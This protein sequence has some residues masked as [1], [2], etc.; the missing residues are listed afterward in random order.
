MKRIEQ[1][2]L[3]DPEME[4]LQMVLPSLFTIRNDKTCV[5]NLAFF[6][7]QVLKKNLENIK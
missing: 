4:V 5:T 7:Y 3:S 1:K 6:L 2:D